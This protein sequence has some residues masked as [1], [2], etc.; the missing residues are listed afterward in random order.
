MEPY[1]ERVIAERDEVAAF[2]NATQD[3]LIKL[4]DFTAT[5]AFTGLPFEQR[6]LLNAQAL[7]M[8]EVVEH[9]NALSDVLQSRISTF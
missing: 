1:Q 7:L 5:P 9:C 2:A 4:V 6:E 3:R 8:R